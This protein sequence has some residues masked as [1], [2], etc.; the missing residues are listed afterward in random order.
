MFYGIQKRCHCSFGKK[1]T[2][3]V[4]E[5][6]TIYKKETATAI[7]LVDKLKMFTYDKNAVGMLYWAKITESSAS[8]ESIY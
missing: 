1:W 7:S 2:R 5:V 3:L 6:N 4:I 8:S